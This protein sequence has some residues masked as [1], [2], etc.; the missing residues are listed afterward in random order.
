MKRLIPFLFL[1]GV[2]V[3]QVISGSGS[4]PIGASGTITAL[5]IGGPLITTANPWPSATV[6]QQYNLSLT[7]QGGTPPYKFQLV[8]ASNTLPSP[9]TIPSSGAISCVPANGTNGTYNPVVQVTDAL[10]FANGTG[11]TFTLVVNTAASITLTG[12]CPNGQNSEPYSCSIAINGGQAPYT[13]SLN[14]GSLPTGVASPVYNGNAAAPACN[15]QGTPNVAVPPAN[16]TFVVHAVDNVGATGNSGSQTITISAASATLAGDDNFYETQSSPSAPC[17]PTWGSFDGVS[18][19]PLTCMNTAMANTPSSGTVH[20]VTTSAGL[21]GCLNSPVTCTGGSLSCGDIIKLQVPS[22]DPD[23]NYSGQFVLPALGCTSTSW[24]AIETATD[25]T[26]SSLFPPE[27]QRITPCYAGHANYPDGES[28]PKAIDATG[29]SYPPYPCNVNGGPSNPARVIPKLTETE[30]TFSNKSHMTLTCATGA[31]FYRLIGLEITREGGWSPSGVVALGG[32]DH[33]IL[34]RDF[35]HSR[36]QSET[37]I[38]LSMATHSGGGGATN[39]A[40]VDSYIIENGCLADVGNCVDGYGVGANSITTLKIVNDFIVG[41]AE[42][43][44]A[45]AAHTTADYA[46]DIDMRRDYLYKPLDWWQ[47]ASLSLGP[48]NGQVALSGTLQMSAQI[49]SISAATVSYSALS[50]T[51][52]GGGTVAASPTGLTESGS[53]VTLTTLAPHNF[54]V[55]DTINI[56]GASVSGYNG[57]FK[58]LTVP[59]STTLTYTALSTNLAASGSGTVGYG[60]LVHQERLDVECIFTYHAPA[61]GTTDTVTAKSTKANFSGTATATVALGGT[62]QVHN[63]EIEPSDLSANAILNQANSGLRPGAYRQFWATVDGS[64]GTQMAGYGKGGTAECPNNSEPG[65][66]TTQNIVTWMVCD[67]NKANCQTGG[68]STLGFIDSKGGIYQA[69]NSLTCPSCTFPMTVFIEALANVDNQSKDFAQVLISPTAYYV[70]IG[71]PAYF[72]K[73]AWENKSAQR[74]F[75]EA[76]ITENSFKGADQEAY[77]WLADPKNQSSTKYVITAAPGGLSAVCTGAGVPPGP[78]CTVTVNV[79]AAGAAVVGN[80]LNICPPGAASVAVPCSGNGTGTDTNFQYFAGVYFISAVNSS[81]QFTYQCGGNGQRACVTGL[82]N[83]LTSG[84]TGGGTACPTAACAAL[85]VAPSAAVDNLVWRYSIARNACSFFSVGVG[86]SDN[87]APPLDEGFIEAHDDYGDNINCQTFNPNDISNNGFTL[88]IAGI[89]GSTN[90]VF[91]DIEFSHITAFTTNNFFLVGSSSAS[92]GGQN[93]KFHDS[94]LGSSLSHGS[95]TAIQPNIC[96]GAPQAILDCAFSFAN[97]QS[98][99]GGGTCGTSTPGSCNGSLGWYQNAFIL[100][101]NM[102]TS[103]PTNFQPSVFDAPN[104][105]APSGGVYP[106]SCAGIVNFANGNGG[107]Y[108]VCTGNGTAGSDNSAAPACTAASIFAAGQADQ[109]TD[110]KALGADIVTV[111]KFT[112]GVDVFH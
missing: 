69:P 107:D 58:V 79:T 3:G 44:F 56:S 17:V 108:R 93:V 20:T 78:P 57:S 34:D 98:T 19:L 36:E 29:R 92:G 59:S 86:S 103:T 14:S 52:P 53:T 51:I 105:G 7:V 39:I 5:P 26:N 60:C 48:Q 18:Q 22:S 47:R 67:Q 65:Q 96:G 2:A 73:N 85:S 30:D 112:N 74:E 104:C 66:L 84:N 90:P 42:D 13:C 71:G 88:E 83:L 11:Q 64:C 33:V 9:C 62:P 35:I 23:G 1:L 81:T 21:L 4:S 32:C 72:V 61:S 12:S 31:N 63:V 54:S 46:T 68:S 25:I 89:G 80:N 40:A 55:G 8:S 6:G 77:S 76:M 91:H 49:Y 75:V 97:G 110:G 70:H 106:A 10:G 99:G 45:T 28:G 16:F 111:N 27:Q 95:I 50:G 94:L 37:T 102:F 101:T 41:G 43:Y 38:T 109:G 15:I 24:V 82:V 100:G 87:G